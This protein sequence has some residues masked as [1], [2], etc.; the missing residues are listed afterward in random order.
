MGKFNTYLKIV[1]YMII[2]TQWQPHFWVT[3]YNVAL[4]QFSSSFHR[5]LTCFRIYTCCISTIIIILFQDFWEVSL[6][7]KNIFIIHLP[8]KIPSHLRC[9]WMMKTCRLDFI[10]LFIWL[11]V[12]FLL[13]LFWK[14]AWRLE[15]VL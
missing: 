5:C 2:I 10:L 15:G 8:L 7:P 12:S 9:S 3:F 1:I 13:A 6:G 4:S 14:G 11:N